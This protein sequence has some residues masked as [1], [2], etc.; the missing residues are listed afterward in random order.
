[1]NYFPFYYENNRYPR[2]ASN[3]T[4]NRKVSHRIRHD[5]PMESDRSGSYG[6][7][8]PRM[9]LQTNG[10][11]SPKL[12]RDFKVRIL[13]HHRLP[14]SDYRSLM[15]ANKSRQ[16]NARYVFVAFSFSHF[17]LNDNARLTEVVR[18]GN[19]VT[20]QLGYKY[21][22]ISASCM[23]FSEPE[24]ALSDEQRRM[25]EEQDVRSRH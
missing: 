19:K 16:A 2:I 4:D 7:I 9:L 6:L 21:F 23:G 8:R 12:V 3:P 17:P 25:I 14:F 22:W 10:N 11:S 20:Q 15:V 24:R 13:Q 18:V 1:V 5:Q